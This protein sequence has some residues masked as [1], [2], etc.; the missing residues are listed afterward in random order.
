MDNQKPLVINFEKY[1][2]VTINFNQPNDIKNFYGDYVNGVCCILGKN[3]SGKSNIIE[4]FINKNSQ[5]KKI[6][7]APK[8]NT[9]I[10]SSADDNFI[11]I[12]DNGKYNIEKN[13]NLYKLWYLSYQNYSKEIDADLKK[14]KSEITI[15]INLSTKTNLQDFNDKLKQSTLS[16]HE[17]E[18]IY[19]FISEEKDDF[20]KTL[21]QIYLNGFQNDVEIFKSLQEIKL[22]KGL[23]FFDSFSDFVS[24]SLHHFIPL[25]EIFKDIETNVVCLKLNQADRLLNYL[26]FTPQIMDYFVFSILYDRNESFYNFSTGDANYLDYIGRL[27]FEIKKQ[28]LKEAKLDSMILIFDEIDIALHP[29]RQKKLFKNLLENLQSLGDDLK[30]PNNIFTILMTSHSP[31]IASDIPSENIVYV[32]MQNGHTIQIENKINSFA[33]NIHLILKDSFFLPTGTVGEFAAD[34]VGKEI[35]SKLYPT[36]TKIDSSKKPSNDAIDNEDL[37]VKKDEKNL[38][39][40]DDD[41]RILNH[42]KL[43]GEPL[44]KK[45]LL[46]DYATLVENTNEDN[47]SNQIKE[48]QKIIETL[49]SKLPNDTNKDNR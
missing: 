40:I 39:I 47:I 24:E 1:P 9:K 30:L 26:L 4:E 5:I 48:F 33:N 36:Q 49:K 6:Y 45:K 13:I 37:K 8:L 23:T 2:N 25:F 31:F 32:E 19:D 20:K 3:G 11:D 35:T 42:I 28:Y 29:E 38:R 46:S 27:L 16:D 12:S 43:I 14:I 17:K 44:I 41:N 34:I 18:I 21:F 10:I 7:F 22:N 15:Q